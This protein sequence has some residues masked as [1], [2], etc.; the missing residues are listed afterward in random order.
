MRL[1]RPNYLRRRSV[2][3]TGELSGAPQQLGELVLPGSEPFTSASG[4]PDARDDDEERIFHHHPSKKCGGNRSDI[5]ESR[6]TSPS[7]SLS[8][9]DEVDVGTSS[10][11][12]L[13]DVSATPGCNRYVKIGS[14]SVIGRGQFSCVV[15]AIDSKLMKLCAIKEVNTTYESNRG[16]AEAELNF[17]QSFGGVSVKHSNIVVVHRALVSQSTTT[18]VMEYASMGSMQDVIDAVGVSKVAID[19]CENDSL[20]MART[21]ILPLSWISAIGNAVFSALNYLHIN[22]YVHYD[23]K[24]TNVLLF[25][26]GEVK[27]A[28]FGCCRKFDTN[29][30]EA[31]GQPTCTDGACATTG[32]TLAFMSPEQLLGSSAIGAK[33]D[34]FSTG[35]TLLECIESSSDQERCGCGYWDV[36]EI[37]EMRTKEIKRRQDLPC[38][39]QRLLL[40]CFRQE[41]DRP[42]ASAL[43]EHDFLR[44]AKAKIIDSAFTRL[45]HTIPSLPRATQHE[46]DETVEEMKERHGACVAKAAATLLTNQ[47]SHTN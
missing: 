11:I 12:P 13:K 45:A 9:I 14:N 32:G 21:S 35:L 4:C 44:N 25:G 38:A 26:S 33:S 15:R 40:L 6:D 29:Q 39:L 34:I 18:F 46:I 8:W 2:A 3:L 22:D 36:L 30:N 31:L 27:L 28:D 42:T 20:A 19:E 16:Q 5:I 17:F 24:P 41:D 23:V 10:K 1:D 37:T 47:L 7:S 43:L